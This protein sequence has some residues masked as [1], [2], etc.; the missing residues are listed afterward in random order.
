MIKKKTLSESEAFLVEQENK[1][2]SSSFSVSSDQFHWFSVEFEQ[3]ADVEYD[4][5]VAELAVA[6][7]SAEFKIKIC[8]KISLFSEKVV[9]F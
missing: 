3:N 8:K 4:I 2:F 1:A 6:V 7:N 9:T 5:S